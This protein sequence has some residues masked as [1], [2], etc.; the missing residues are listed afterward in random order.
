MSVIEKISIG[1]T[2]Q[3]IGGDNF[4]GQWVES[5]ATLSSSFTLAPDGSKT[6]S[7]TSY[8]PDSTYDYEVQFELTAQTGTTSGNYVETNIYSGS[9]GSNF[10]QRCARIRTRASNYQVGATVVVVP[11]LASDQNVR[12]TTY[13]GSSGT[14]TL[15]LYAKRYRRIGK[16]GTSSGY[17]SKINVGGTS[18]EI[19]GDFIDG[20][21]TAAS[22]QL[23]SGTLGADGSSTLDLSNILPN[24]GNA[25]EC[26]FSITASTGTSSGNTVAPR[27]G[28]QSGTDNPEVC[29]H[30]TRTSSNMNCAGNIRVPCAG[31]TV[32][33]YNSGN[34]TSGTIT[35]RIR[36]YRRIGTNV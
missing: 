24:D 10:R 20:Q 26:M 32:Q 15:G 34:D 30:V 35:V 23:F 33:L 5:L 7:L 27:L 1:G 28:V 3:Q 36:G 22:D 31:R 14:A 25:Y 4:D 29:Q 8:L 18:Y 21:W 13:S 6:F 11:I 12:V 17:I 9:S 19:G 16:N 2:A